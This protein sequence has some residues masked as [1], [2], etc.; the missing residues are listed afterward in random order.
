MKRLSLRKLSFLGLILMAASAVTAAILPSDTKPS[1]AA[2]GLANTTDGAT[3][4][5][6]GAGA[7]CNDT[8]ASGTTSGGASA[9]SDPLNPRTSGNTTD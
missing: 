8:A 1:Y 3:C 4:T 7:A 2:A 5:A 9:T 6:N